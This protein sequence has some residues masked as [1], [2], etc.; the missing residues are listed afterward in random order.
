MAKKKH[1]QESFRITLSI[2]AYSNPHLYKLL[3]PDTGGGKGAILRNLAEEA[4]LWREFRQERGL[5]PVDLKQ[6][7]QKLALYQDSGIRRFSDETEKSAYTEKPVYADIQSKI[8]IKTETEKSA[9][10]DKPVYADITA[11]KPTMPEPDKNEVTPPKQINKKMEL[12]Y[13]A[14]RELAMLMI[15][16]EGLR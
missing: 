6:G 9:Y 14:S 2:S 5:Q 13:S 3:K 1:E 11:I 7:F 12:K 15:E 16:K 4:L 8:P 10:T